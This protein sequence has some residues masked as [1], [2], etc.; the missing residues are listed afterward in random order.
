MI[1]NE[2]FGS[3]ESLRSGSGE[4]EVVTACGSFDSR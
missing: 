3:S 4:A 1:E 2:V